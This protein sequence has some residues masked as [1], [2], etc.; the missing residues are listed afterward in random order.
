[1]EQAAVDL[2][3]E[4]FPDAEVIYHSMRPWVLVMLCFM[5]FLASLFYCWLPTFEKYLAR[6]FFLIFNICMGALFGLWFIGDLGDN[7]GDFAGVANVFG[8]LAQFYLYRL[9]SVLLLLLPYGLLLSLLYVLGKF[10]K[11]NEIVAMIQSGY[12]IV[13]ITRPLLFAGIWCSVFLL[14]LNFHWAPQSE[15]KKEELTSLAKGLPMYEARNVLFRDPYSQRLWLVGIFPE[16]FREKGKLE[17]VEVT[18]LRADG[19]LKNRISAPIVTWDRETKTWIFGKPTLTEFRKGESPIFTKLKEPLIKNWAETPAQ[20]I[21]PSLNVDFLGLPDLSS[22]LNSP[23][24]EQATSNRLS[25]LTHW[26]HRWALPFSCLVTVILAAPLSIYFTRKGVGSG[27]FLAI[28]LSVL[29]LFFTSIALSFGEAGMLPPIVSAWATNLGFSLLGL[30][31]YRKR[32]SGLPITHLL[33]RVMN[34]S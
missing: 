25:Y 32:M 13:R 26:H 21:K 11:S 10:S 18:T 27:V 31:L 23:L 14:G 8:T 34:L 24:A 17:H 33:K 6:E 19:S 5:P 9:P 2:H 7:L 20:I 16:N 1:M 12:S 15:G 29:M 28:L 30:W 4:G 3:L 22:W